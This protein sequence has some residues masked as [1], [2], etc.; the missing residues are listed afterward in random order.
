MLNITCQHGC[1]QVEAVEELSEKDVRL[2]HV[3]LVDLF[4]G[5]KDVNHPFEMLLTRRHPY[6]VDLK[7]TNT[8]SGKRNLCSK[9]IWGF[10][11]V[12]PQDF[13]GIL[14]NLLNKKQ[15]SALKVVPT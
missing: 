6:E 8:K 2:N 4:N 12:S 3:L 7:M 1:A 15:L 13:M 11:P 10:F 5:V 14:V 9:L